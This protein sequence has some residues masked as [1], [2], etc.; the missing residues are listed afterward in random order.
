MS[1]RDVDERDAAFFQKA[2]KVST[3]ACET[4]G[5]VDRCLSAG[6]ID[7]DIGIAVSN[8]TMLYDVADA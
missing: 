2:S 6:Q 5:L 4:D 7:C 8:A 1:V 3:A